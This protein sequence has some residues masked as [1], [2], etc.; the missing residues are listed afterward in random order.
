M[1]RKN[2]N[3]PCKTFKACACAKIVKF[4]KSR[5]C[6]ISGYICWLRS[7]GLGRSTQG[8]LLTSISTTSELFLLPE[9]SLLYSTHSGVTGISI[10]QVVM[11]QIICHTYCLQHGSYCTVSAYAA[12]FSSQGGPGLPIFAEA[13]FVY[14]ST[15]NQPGYSYGITT[16]DQVFCWADTEMFFLLM[17][18]IMMLVL[19]YRWAVH[20]VMKNYRHSSAVIRNW[21]HLFETG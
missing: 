19:W 16:N 21:R 6:Y 10:H 3:N 15:I 8:I 14:F 1:L 13:T 20:K 17:A 5:K 2:E 9:L 7:T 12:M 11:I 18:T 4:L